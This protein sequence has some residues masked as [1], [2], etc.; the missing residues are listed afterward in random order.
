MKAVILHGEIQAEAPLDEQDTFHWRVDQRLQEILNAVK[1]QRAFS[2]ER[3]SPS[4]N[5]APSGTP[6]PR[7]PLPGKNSVDFNI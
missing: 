6:N 4:V 1:E 2:E 7:P 3:E 5:V